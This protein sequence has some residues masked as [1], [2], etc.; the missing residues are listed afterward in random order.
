MDRNSDQ[1]VFEKNRYAEW[2]LKTQA[3]IGQTYPEN[4]L[5]TMKREI[6]RSNFSPVV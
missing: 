2:L 5:D 1:L 6:G 4:S 3:S